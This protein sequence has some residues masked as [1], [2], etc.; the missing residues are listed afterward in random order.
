MKRRFQIFRLLRR[1]GTGLALFAMILQSLGEAS[2]AGAMAAAVTGNLNPLTGALGLLQ[3]C[4][5][6]GIVEIDPRQL[7]PDNKRSAAQPCPLCSASALGAFTIAR[8]HQVH[9]PLNRQISLIVVPRHISGM[10]FISGRMGLS[11]APPV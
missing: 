10:G 8:I 6:M 3:I 11:R 4:T 2:H 7:V 5:P 9:V 1:T